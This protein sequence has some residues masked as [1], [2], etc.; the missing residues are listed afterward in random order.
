[1]KVPRPPVH[2]FHMCTPSVLPVKV[3]RCQLRDFVE[4]NPGYTSFLAQKQGL[5][6]SDANLVGGTTISDVAYAATGS[7]ATAPGGGLGNADDGGGAMD[8]GQGP[9]VFWERSV[10]L[11]LAEV[12]RCVRWCCV[13]Y[14]CVWVPGSGVYSSSTAIYPWLIS[15]TLPREDFAPSLPEGSRRAFRQGLWFV[16]MLELVLGNNRVNFG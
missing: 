11:R 7:L 12:F 9:V 15:L 3:L 14:V 5:S 16:S 13:V 4:R 1:M 10:G 2:P 6:L 8:A